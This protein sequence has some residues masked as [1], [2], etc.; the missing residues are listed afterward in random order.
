MQ[1]QNNNFGI[2]ETAEALQ[3]LAQFAN[4]TA[5]VTADGK[6][7]LI[8][9]LQFATLWPV[10]SP[11]VDGYKQIPQELLDLDDAERASLKAT[12]ASALKLPQEK[13]E[14][15]FEDGLD[16]SLHILQFIGQI[17]DLK[18]QHAQAV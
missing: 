13:T 10:I 17:R 18:A 6:V 16:L 1:S 5:N 12:F 2:K 3:F 4:V 14:I 9:L 11:A 15:I 8:E 7:T